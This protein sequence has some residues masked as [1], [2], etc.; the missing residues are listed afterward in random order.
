[1]K[2]ATLE[3]WV[4]LDLLQTT[5]GKKA[6]LVAGGH[7]AGRRFSFRT[8]FGA[9]ECNDVAGHTLDRLSVS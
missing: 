5:W 7:V 4:E 9:F 6:F 1:M 3:R 8:S 2:G